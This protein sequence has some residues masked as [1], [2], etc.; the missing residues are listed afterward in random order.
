ML[1]LFG[2]NFIMKFCIQIQIIVSSH[3]K[4]DFEKVIKSTNY[5]NIKKK[6][7][8]KQDDKRIN[9]SSRSN[10]KASLLKKGAAKTFFQRPLNMLSANKKYRTNDLSD[11]M[12][13]FNTE[14]Q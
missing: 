4:K 8:Y 14:Q 6:K 11:Q 10:S 1:L 12:F 9:G 5:F 7:M 13:I 2:N 3:R